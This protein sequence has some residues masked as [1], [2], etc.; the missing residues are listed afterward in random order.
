[1]GRRLFKLR[2][3]ILAALALNT[4]EG[5]N[6]HIHH[7]RS[8]DETGTK[9]KPNILIILADDVGTGDVPVYWNNSHMFDMPNIQRLA[10]MGV[11]FLD[12]HA[13]PVCAPSRYMLLSGNYQHRGRVAR[14]TWD[15]TGDHNQFQDHQKSIA[16][17]LRDKGNY[18]T[19]VFG[20]WHVGGK[21]PENNANEAGTGT[22]KTKLNKLTHEG[23]DWSQPLIEGPQDI[24]FTSSY[25]TPNG[26]Q[27]SPY[28]FL[29]D[30]YLT[31]NVSDAKFWR[32]GT[33]NRIRGKSM[34]QR[35]GE[36]DPDWD[37]TA[38]NMI[39]IN[40]TEAFLDNHIAN[41]TGDDP[42]FAYVALGAVHGP[43]SP[44]DHYLDGTVIA[45]RYPS[46]HMDMLFEMDKAVGSLVSMVEDRGLANNTIIIFASD[47]G[48]VKPSSGSFEYGLDSHGPLR[49]WK[50]TVYEG[51]HRIPLMFRWDGE[52]PAGETRSK[53]V[54]ITDIYETICDIA[55]IKKPMASAQDSISFADYIYSGN[56]TSSL[57]RDYG[58]WKY[59][60]K[61]IVEESIRKDNMK[62]VIRYNQKTNRR[63]LE[64]FDLDNDISET[65]NI[66]SQEKKLRRTLVRRLRKMGPCPKKDNEE[67][68]V[69]EEAAGKHENCAFFQ[70]DTR[71][72][73]WFIA[74]EM[75]CP[76]ICPSRHAHICDATFGNN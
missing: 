60:K 19:A 10:N 65:T 25:I 23:Y 32:K 50:G 54:S 36:G 74:G 35:R 48:G 53:L 76:S 13:S 14:G 56:N 8:L 61:R 29:R 63:K 58:V 21:I 20:K 17:A 68:F 46:A 5:K 6:I 15:I 27:Q 30:G 4:T 43:H 28:S 7:A 57:R 11:T 67:S 26:I 33:Y 45:G 24:G 75:N 44:P 1:M 34:I 51:G 40:E 18:S 31:T 42:F 38:Y 59:S 55:D 37:S 70:E 49:G 9:Q 72:C 2:V 39:L 71:R 64:L 62:L 52:F 41:K 22:A 69:L 3:I 12:A 16:E 73:E 47:N 66:A